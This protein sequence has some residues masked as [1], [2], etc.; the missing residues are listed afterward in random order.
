MAKC[1]YSL[2]PVQQKRRWKGVVGFDS[3]APESSER[4]EQLLNGLE[5]QDFLKGAIPLQPGAIGLSFFA[6]FPLKKRLDIP[7]GGIASP[8]NTQIAG[9][10]IVLGKYKYLQMNEDIYVFI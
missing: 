1:G 10:E 8:P 7:R 6:R 9:I 4:G 5:H 3:A 2:P